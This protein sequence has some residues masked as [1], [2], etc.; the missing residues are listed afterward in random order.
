MLAALGDRFEIFDWR[1]AIA[2]L[3]NVHAGEA[4][5]I[6]AVL[7]AFTLRHSEEAVGGGDKSR[8]AAFID[9]GLSERGWIE[10]AFDT[11]IVV[12][13]VETPSPTHGVDC[14][15][16][17][18]ALEVEWN[19][20]DPFFDRDLNNFRLLYDLRVV[21]VGVIVTRATSLEKVLRGVGRSATTYGKAT[22]HTEKLYPKIKGGGAGGCPAPVLGITERAY[23][24]DRA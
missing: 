15:R 11:R 16:G 13:G 6:A 9:K 19:N 2:I 21:D 20:K 17:R 7:G 4:A 10:K 12:D 24:D 14:F 23:V 18:V 1:N 22:A 5:D 3:E 8:I